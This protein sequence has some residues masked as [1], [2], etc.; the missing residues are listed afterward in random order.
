MIYV[1]N[2]KRDSWV[3]MSCHQFIFYNYIVLIHRKR[4]MGNE[5]LLI[6]RQLGAPSLTSPLGNDTILYYNKFLYII[7]VNVMLLHI[8]RKERVQ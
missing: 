4:R 8:D 7:L 3:E 2:A 1:T 6:L 5:R